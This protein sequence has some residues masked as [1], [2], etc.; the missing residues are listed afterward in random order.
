MKQYRKT[1]PCFFSFH[2]H[3]YPFIIRFSVN[4][5]A[6]ELC[7]EDQVDGE[8]DLTVSLIHSCT[9][10]G[11]IIPFEDGVFLAVI[12]GYDGSPDA[13]SVI[14]HEIHHLA[15]F[16]FD[17]IGQKPDVKND[18]CSAYLHGF[19]TNQFYEGLKY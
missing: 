16:I 6:E 10:P 4:Q 12:K 7:A 1:P 2:T 19:I 5:T 17:R 15:N 8:D 13:H 18:E 14:A 11:R 9:T 3:L